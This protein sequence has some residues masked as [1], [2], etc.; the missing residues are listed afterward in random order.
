M[1][2]CSESASLPLGTTSAKALACNAETLDN[3]ANSETPTYVNR[4]GKTRSTLSGI[5]DRA[6]SAIGAIG[7][8]DNGFYINS[9]L[10]TEYNQYVKFDRAGIIETYKVKTTT[11]L[12]YQI[13]FGATPDPLNDTNLQLFNDATR[14]WVKDNFRGVFENVSDAKLGDL[15]IGDSIDTNGYYSS[16][17]G[18]A[19]RYV[20]SNKTPDGYVDHLMSN[21]L[22]L[23]LISN[24]VIDILQA[25]GTYGKA[26]AFQ[27][28]FIAAALKNL[29]DSAIDEINPI[30]IGGTVTYNGLLHIGSEQI[31][32]PPYCEFIYPGVVPDSI[33]FGPGGFAAAPDDMPILWIDVSYTAKVIP[34]CLSGYWQAGGTSPGQL[35]NLATE[36]VTSGD[37]DL[38]NIQTNRGSRFKALC[39]TDQFCV[40][41]VQIAAAHGS[42]IEVCALG[43]LHPYLA[44][45]TWDLTAKIG[46]FNHHSGGCFYNVN[47]FRITGYSNKSSAGGAPP[48]DA[49]TFVPQWGPENA[50]QNPAALR[51][52]TVGTSGVFGSAIDTSGFL[53]QSWQRA[54]FCQSVNGWSETSPYYEGISDILWHSV[55]SF[56]SSITPRITMTGGGVFRC[57]GDT[58][59]EIQN[60]AYSSIGNIPS[61]DGGIV[62]AFPDAKMRV[63]LRD[64]ASH[65]WSDHPQIKFQF[66]SPD[67]LSIKVD[68]VG[69]DDIYSGLSE[70]KKVKTIDRA[71][72]MSAK[73]KAIDVVIDH[74][75]TAVI[76]NLTTYPDS[77]RF[78]SSDIG[79]TN[80]II[81]PVVS[82]GVLNGGIAISD[83]I[84]F[85]HVDVDCLA[86]TGG[87]SARGLI[88][89]IGGT[90]RVV[91]SNMVLT[92]QANSGLMAAGENASSAALTFVFDQCTKAGTGKIGVNAFGSNGLCRTILAATSNID[93]EFESNYS[94]LS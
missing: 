12:S 79:Q 21:G 42:K 56:F 8:V 35:V 75:T 49:S 72:E 7:G 10:M 78:L 62:T 24:R 25:G 94:L 77:V 16:S 69:G 41:P 71:L 55:S 22:T 88:R 60:P 90:N 1:S 11:P 66:M 19:G 74:S 84:T 30:T 83:Q 43:F 23:E 93:P 57:G 5:E 9:P 20:V 64:Q 58:S 59:G 73:Y 54:R 48:L 28:E 80:P 17:S 65:Q 92:T 53:Q 31:Q 14:A 26:A 29:N 37:N 67:D 51:E 86:T 44:A 4:V 32:I 15:S 61:W 68:P 18:G 76:E 33:D 82:G 47:G 46:G 27:N 3:F 38:G 85:D 87:G 81:Q 89:I 2:N 50:T 45:T 70:F 36:N 52:M 91:C 13:N 6:N 39:F 63:V 40:A 34:F